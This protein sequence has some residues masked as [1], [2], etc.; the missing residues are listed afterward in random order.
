MDENPFSISGVSVMVVVLATLTLL[1]GC[2][3]TRKEVSPLAEACPGL[4]AAEV[5]AID[6]YAATPGIAFY[7]RSYC[8]SIEEAQRRMAL[9]SRDDIGPRAE[10]GPVPEP[11]GIGTGELSAVLRTNEAATFA[12]IWIQH[13]PDYGVVV[14]FTHDAAATLARYTTDPLFMPLDRPGP[15]LAELHQAQQRL[16]R[17]FTA[18]GFRW[19]GASVREDLGVVEFDLAQ[20]AAPIRA[21]AARGAF[22]LPGWVVLNEPVPLPFAAPPPPAPGDTRVRAFPQLAF[23]TDMYIRTVAGVQDLPATLLLQDGC[24]V[25]EMDGVTRTALWQASDALDLS[26]PARVAVVNRLDGVRVAEGDNIVLMGLQPGEEQVPREL[27]DTSGCGG[28][29][30]QV[31][32]FLPHAHWEAQQREQQIDR[33]ERTL[34]S[35]AAAI[36]DYEAYQARLPAL[37]AWRD[38]LLAD[39]SDVVAAI[40][41]EEDNATA[42]LFHTSA[43]GSEDLVP[44]SLAPFVESREAPVGHGALE[45]ARASLQ[46]QLA[47][48]GI[49]ATLHIDPAEGA[50][51]VS[52]ADPRALS[53]AAAGGAITFPGLARVIQGGASA[54]SYEAAREGSDPDAAWFRLEAAPDF[55]AIRALV[56]ATEL[57]VIE[58]PPQPSPG[59]GPVQSAEPGPRRRARPGRAASLRM[60]HYLVAYGQSAAEIAALRTH[61]FDPVDAFDA[62]NGRSTQVTRALLARDVVVAELV[63]LETRAAHRDGFRSSTQWRV[64]ETLKGQT[65][66]G[67][68]VHTRMISGD[69][70][71]G[72]IAQA[73]DEPLVLPGMPGSLEQGGLWL[74][75]L[76]DA[77]YLHQAFVHGGE[78]AARED[79]RWDVLP[80]A[81]APVVDDVVLAPLPGQYSYPLAELRAALAP[82][83]A[84]VRAA[85]PAYGGE[86]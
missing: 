10:P 14:A 53:E 70:P 8:V 81:P 64:V 58:P 76:N 29:Y 61:G 21:A 52:P 48:A 23:R 60:A 41:L 47:E 82:L 78:G 83:Q 1:P 39:D 13:Q 37:R 55:A 66:P 17:E 73:I 18:R 57:P 25:L 56:D 22:A 26:D 3:A 54:L 4:S 75:H 40:W 20:E 77:L 19:A 80:F 72:G 63:S 44:A 7:A 69:D 45:S 46:R 79:A 62:M 32:G 15:V 9:Q 51:Y 42:Y 68:V 12:G 11:P 28:P 43:S 36:A 74:L 84:A 5:E 35:R 38:R 33:R 59:A 85:G 49:E 67:A 86:R 16:T 27:V 6:D 31:R 65:W 50:V 34:G 30:Q 71:D 2:T 24:L